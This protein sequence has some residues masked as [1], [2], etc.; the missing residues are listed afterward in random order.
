LGK[1]HLR[2]TQLKAFE[3]HLDASLPA[4]FSGLY[5]LIG[6]DPK[7]RYFAL[8]VLKKKMRQHFPDLDS[9]TYEADSQGE[10]DFLRDLANRSLF[11]K[12]QLLHL[13]NCEKLSKALGASLE[14][15][16]S[17]THAFIV[18]TGE[19]LSRNS[20]FYK[21]LEK[22]GV[23]LDLVE[24]KPWE[25]ERALAE[26]LAMRAAKSNQTIAPDA[27]SLLTS[28]A[29]GSF[30][31]LASEWD[32]LQNYADGRK[33][34][35]LADVKAVCILTPQ[36]N[37][38]QLGEALLQRDA[39][40]A[41]KAAHRS[42]SQGHALFSILRQL[43]HQ[44]MTALH[45]LSFCEAGEQE[46]IASK[47]P[48][49]KGGFLEKQLSAAQRYG[50]ESL[51]QAIAVIDAAEFKAKDGWDDPHTLLTFLVGSL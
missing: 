49:L 5:C 8:D 7:E 40:S 25:R 20:T 15:I 24:E 42:L 32:K 12:K 13:G 50:K 28:G 21:E 17:Q 41:Q 26:W 46:K 51:A 22:R 1:I 23:I 31:L 18:L 39:A 3:K 30:A 35:T 2:Y 33:I 44:F 4:H 47:Y 48:Y 45:V 34:I 38:W 19:T 9:K 43:R 10:Q 36:D 16:L 14:K 27:M 37:T 29:S 11:A 6:K